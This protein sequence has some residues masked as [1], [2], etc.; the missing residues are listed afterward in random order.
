[1]SKRAH[2][3]CNICCDD[4][5]RYVHS[6]AKCDFVTCRS[7]ARRICCEF[8]SNGGA[9]LKCHQLWTTETLRC[10]LGITFYKTVYRTN[11]R[12]Q[13]YANEELRF[14]ETLQ[15]VGTEK[16]RRE[17]KALASR[18]S[19]DIHNG[20]RDL[21][22]ER[23]RV[24]TAIHRLNERTHTSHPL[25]YC[26]SEAC[27]G[28][29]IDERGTCGKCPTLTC[30]HCG[31]RKNVGHECTESSV[32]SLRT[33]RQDCR[34]CV[35]CAAPSMR[36][37]GCAV[38]WCVHC[39]TFWH[40]DTMRVID[41]KSNPPHNPD[42]HEWLSNG[43]L[44]RSREIGDVPCGGLPEG[45]ELHVALLRELV[46]GF[47]VTSFA[48]DVIGAAD[49]I[50]YAQRMRRQYPLWWNDARLNEPLRVAFLIGDIDQDRFSRCLERQERVNV[51]RRDIGEVLGTFVLAAA[52]I[53]QR[54]CS[55]ESHCVETCISI[56]ALRSLTNTTLRALGKEHERTVPILN[57]R[58]VW[59][60]P[61]SRRH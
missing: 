61:F 39:H 20:R 48:Q 35:R 42:H 13:L 59:E 54:F 14:A 15:V 10:L 30:I 51:F 43:N 19:T 55:T 56:D 34:P 23:H 2:K 33:I 1:M 6:C 3:E 32:Q 8:S 5:C 24:Y 9:C 52:D 47:D 41:V 12:K 18:L 36:T 25:I 53:F 37:E 31:E 57:D 21:I 11:R 4:G 40:W 7:C 46:L 27:N 44:N 26:S 28:Y 50:H 58:W 22:S 38:M 45:E 17:L 49:A 16:R 29:V 60:Q